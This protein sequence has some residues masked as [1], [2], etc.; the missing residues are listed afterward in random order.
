MD[1][2][3]LLLI[4]AVAALAGIVGL[5]VLLMQ[6]PKDSG[7]QETFEPPRQAPPTPEQAPG[8]VKQSGTLKGSVVSGE[9][10]KAIADAASFSDASHLHHAFVDVYG[11]TPARYRREG[12]P[13]SDQRVYR[14][15]ERVDVEDYSP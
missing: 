11:A 15:I 8:A 9:T 12:Q 1:R 6:P 3:A 2:R 4:V 14:E 7:L 5:I 13:V 10:G